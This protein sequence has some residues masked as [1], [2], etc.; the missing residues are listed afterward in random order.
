VV[1]TPDDGVVRVVNHG[2]DHA[3]EGSTGSDSPLYARLGYSTA[4]TPVLDE[5]GWDDPLDQSVVLID[6][7]GRA[8]HRSGMRT[9]ALGVEGDGPDGVGIAGSTSDVHWVDAIPGPDHG[10]GRPGRS[11]PAGRI[12]V[13]SIARG[14][15]ELRLSRVDSLA[16]GIGADQVWLRVGGWALAGPSSPTVDSVSVCLVGPGLR[17]RLVSLTGVPTAGIAEFADA[18][19]LG[20]GVLVPWLKYPARLGAWVATLVELSGAQA[21]PGLHV[22]AAAVEPAGASTLVVRAQW[23]DGRHTATQIN[24]VGVAI[25]GGSKPVWA[26]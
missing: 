24:E 14:P 3:V 5:H 26:R 7:A 20:P 21:P 1:S 12:T 8:T 16:A 23:P 13:F 15:W 19:P 22:A 2:T 18:S 9:I 4:T 6:S 11:T 25:P 17:S 10:E